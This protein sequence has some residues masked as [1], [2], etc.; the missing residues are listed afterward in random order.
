MT[1]NLEQTQ[2]QTLDEQTAGDLLI[3]YLHFAA[4][5]RSGSMLMPYHQAQIRSIVRSIIV[6][7]QHDLQEQIDE[8]REQLRDVVIR[9]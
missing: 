7:A 3:E 1:L 2:E 4:E 9:K 8:L 5:S 6:A